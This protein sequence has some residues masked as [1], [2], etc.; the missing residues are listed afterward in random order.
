MDAGVAAL[1]K[2]VLTKAHV[3]GQAARRRN[4]A[5]PAAPWEQENSG[6]MKLVAELKPEVLLHDTTAGKSRIWLKKFEAY[7]YASNMQVARIQVQ[8]AYE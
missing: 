2:D 5:P 3:R 6:G 8:Q 1:W 4:A 7:Y